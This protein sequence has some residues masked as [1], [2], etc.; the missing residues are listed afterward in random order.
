MKKL[1]IGLVTLSIAPD[2]ERTGFEG[3]YDYLSQQGHNVKVFTGKW[4]LE[5]KDP[6]IIQV[7]LI[8]KSFLWP[9]LY[10]YNVSKYLRKYKLD[11]IHGNSPK[12]TLP[13]LFSKKKR[14]I[15]TIHDLGPYETEF[16]RIPLDKYLI[17]YIAKKATYITTVSQYSKNKLKHFIPDMDINKIHVL[18][19]GIDEKFKPRHE[20]AQ[21]LKE[22][23]KIQGP[24][25]LY[26]GRIAKYKGVG[27]IINAYK[28]VKEVIPD[29]SL[30]IAGRPD[31]SMREK[32]EE[33]SNKY[34]EIIFPGFVP[35]SEVP[36]YYTMADIFINYSYGSEGFG[37]TPLESLACGTPPICSSL[38]VYKEILHDNAIFVPPQSPELL[39]EAM[40]KILQN[41]SLSQR[42]VQKGQKWVKRYT[43]NAVGKKLEEVYE[44]F[45]KSN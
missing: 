13:I 32:F 21:L 1:N 27:D 43:W 36:A 39:A 14:F 8:R 28:R 9:P 4:N 35:E 45:L 34:Q 30:V 25:I 3:I 24:V 29:V 20:E 33:W 38:A 15:S 16:N 31:F 23:L 22:K 19:N 44:K 41:P 2:K 7:N 11:I 40:I 18:Y 12:G 6:N 37:N 26:L 5:I 10:I 17:N 42:I